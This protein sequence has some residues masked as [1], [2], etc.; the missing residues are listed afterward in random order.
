MPVSEQ[1]KVQAT[2]LRVRV[3]VPVCLS[4]CSVYQ[5]GSRRVED[6]NEGEGLW[7]VV[8]AP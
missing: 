3:R 6:G 7:L 1:A 5:K 8:A 4:G 2:S